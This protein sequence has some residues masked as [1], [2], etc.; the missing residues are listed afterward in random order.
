MYLII[1]NDKENENKILKEIKNSSDPIFAYLR[2]EDN[3]E[4]ILNAPIPPRSIIINQFEELDS[5]KRLC[6]EIKVT[7]PDISVG[8]ILN[9]SQTKKS[10]FRYVPEV[11]EELIY[12]FS[13]RDFICFL[14]KL[15]NVSIPSISSSLVCTP[16]KSYLLGYD[17]KLSPSEN[18][19]LLF[20]SAFDG[21]KITAEAICGGCLNS[22]SGVEAVRVLINRINKKAKNISSRSL[23][24]RS[25]EKGYYIN[26]NA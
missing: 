3:F 1:S 25:H 21:K 19:I 7:Y 2:N 11:N 4:D 12:P 6:S 22:G 5:M 8:I 15:H 24:L 18:R 16:N 13:D 23:I 14:K 17:M 9:E 20:L 26:K 10:L